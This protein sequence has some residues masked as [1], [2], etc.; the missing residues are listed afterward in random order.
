M[1]SQ[2]LTPHSSDVSLPFPTTT[3][4]T[5]QSISD[6][7][8]SIGLPS[9]PPYAGII[10]PTIPSPFHST[11]ALAAP[12]VT[13]LVTIKLNSVEDY[14]TWRTQFTSV[15][16]SHEL[17]GFVDGSTPQPTQFLCDVSGNQQ[18]NPLYRSW[19]RVDQSV[20]LWLFATLSREVLVDVHLLPTSRDI[21]IS[22]Q[23]R[24]MDA[25]QAKSIELKRQLTTMRKSDSM[26]IDEYLRE[27]KK[28]ADS[29]AAINSQVS[30]QDFIDHVLLELGREYDTLVGII[31]HYPG[32][33][34]LKELR[35]KLLLH[36][37]WL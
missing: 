13:N 10:E 16:I 20:R 1:A 32:Q 5:T 31:T 15:L 29:L 28:I 35:T 27:A 24:F 25:S 4:A 3:V 33:L 6:I 2:S 7:S 14:L 36:E 12:N 30:T 18:V 8:S 21:W 17:L 37:Q 9:L 11:A 19:V 23:K 22:L 34:S 26:T